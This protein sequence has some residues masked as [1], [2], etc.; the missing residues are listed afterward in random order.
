M[1][2][3]YAPVSFALPLVGC[4]QT[5][6]TMLDPTERPPVPEEEVRVYRTVESIQCRYEEVAL[7]HAQGGAGST[8]EN[9]MI[10][11]AKKR[12]GRVGANGVVLGDIN[13]P[14]AG[15]RI[16]GAIFGVGSERRGEMLA[17]YV[18]EPC[19]AIGGAGGVVNP[20]AVPAP[21]V[22]PADSMGVPSDTTGNGAG[23]GR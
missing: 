23:N 6:A 1:R 15:A 17:V 13:E 14:S 3:V 11:A 21:V 22:A 19:E 7:V 12:A 20:T 5:Q 16:A 2:Y 10:G 8:D 9:Q 18:S 4:V